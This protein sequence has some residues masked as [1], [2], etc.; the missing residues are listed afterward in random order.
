MTS[1]EKGIVGVEE[2]GY[3]HLQV[4]SDD[5]RQQVVGW[6]GVV[7]PESFG[8][9]IRVSYQVTWVLYPNVSPVVGWV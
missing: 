6:E 7:V 4:C 1:A 9:V 5:R 8:A 2:S 3:E